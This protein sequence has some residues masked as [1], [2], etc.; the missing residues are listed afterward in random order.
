MRAENLDKLRNIIRAVLKLD[1]HELVDSINKENSRRWDSLAQMTMVV[2]VE[3]EFD[4]RI[5]TH[6]YEQFVSFDSIQNLL[7][8]KGL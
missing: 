2:A 6:Q 1:V 5:A 3:E 7:K 8:E 4:V